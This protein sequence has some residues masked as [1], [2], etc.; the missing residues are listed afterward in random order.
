MSDPRIGFAGTTQVLVVL[1]EDVTLPTLAGAEPV[2]DHSWL[3]PAKYEHV[4]LLRQL[5]KEHR[6]AVDSDAA[7]VLKRA[8]ASGPNPFTSGV[9][10]TVTAVSGHKPNAAAPADPGS[11]PVIPEPT[12]DSPSAPPEPVDVGPDATVTINT[13]GQL[14]I[15]ANPAKPLVNELTRV[16]GLKWSDAQH[17]WTAPASQ[18]VTIHTI[19]G[20]YNIPFDQTATTAHNDATGPIPYDGTYTG[21]R[22]IPVTVLAGVDKTKAERFETFGITSLYDL[23]MVTPRRYI[24]RSNTIRIKDLVVGEDAAFLAKVDRV[25]VDPARRMVKI[26]LSDGTGR[27]TVVYFNAVWQ[28]KRFRTGDQVLVSGKVDEWVGTSKRVKQIANPMMDPWTE[29]TIPVIPVYPQSAKSRVTTWDIHAAVKEAMSRLGPVNDPYPTFVTNGYIPRDTALRTIHLPDSLAD[30]GVARTRLA[31]DELLTVQTALLFTKQTIA[32]ET[33]VT[34]TSTGTIV[35]PMIDRLPFPLTNAQTRAWTEINA[36]LAAAHP[37]HRLLM[38]DVG[39][40]KTIMSGMTIATAVEAGRQA[41]LMA[42]TEI[43]ATQLYEEFVRLF[44]GLTTPTGDPV[45]VVLVT[46][47]LRGKTRDQVLADLA[48]GA[49]HVAVGTHALIVDDITFH[50]LGVVVVD[51]QHRFGVEQRAALRAKTAEGTRPDMLVMTAT[52]IPRTAAMT[53]FGDLDVSI[54]DELPP[55]RTPI[56]TFWLDQEP[57][58]DQLHGEPW[59]TIR[60]EVANGHQAYVVCPLVE[61]SEKLTV[62]NATETYEALSTGALHGLRLGLVHG[63]QRTDERNEIMNAFRNGDL[64]V[65][66]ATTV[67][68]VGVNVP[69]ATV[70]AILD[71]NRFGIAQLHQLRGRVGRGTAASLCFLVGRCVTA[72]SRARMTAL[73]DSTDGFVL[74]EVDL[75]L[76]GHG[77]MFGT[78]QSGLSDLNVADLNT[79]R[80][81]LELART[82]AND[83]LTTDPGLVN[84]PAVRDEIAAVVGEHGIASLAKS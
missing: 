46:N 23:L 65:L 26:D 5:V 68:E 48:A 73:T 27:L 8:W 83:L 53:V 3:V 30:A 80:D 22:N 10:G 60:T 47:K 54:L 67:I 40:G 45:R 36:D 72:D 75:A 11:A 9:S 21:L 19:A 50:D 55:G 56:S 61:E 79:D 31:F 29:Q 69:N 34:N 74:S 77:S 44:D 4:E 66:V 52:P 71:S 14:L 6:L 25:H 57:T 16:P 39:S 43:L 32:H 17:G 33:G 62:A 64:D 42:P 35:G 76:R 58:F 63:Q 41:A 49:I 70:I 2:G 84:H 24:D 18:L 51:E 7:A 15:H 28:A 37:M 1:P 38:G 13:R 82:A 20:R 81:L 12:P 78:Q 59:D